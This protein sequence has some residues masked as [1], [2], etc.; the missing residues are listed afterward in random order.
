MF[1]GAHLFLRVSSQQSHRDARPTTAQTPM[2]KIHRTQL[3]VFCLLALLLGLATTPAAEIRKANNGDPMDQ[4]SS[5]IGGIAP[6]NT[7]VAV[8]DADSGSPSSPLS[9]VHWQGIRLLETLFLGALTIQGGPSSLTLGDA[10]IDM[11]AA[12]ADMD[13]NCSFVSLAADQVWNI[14]PGR[15][16]TLLPENPG[17]GALYKTGPGTLKLYYS[18]AAS[19]LSDTAA[20]GLAGGTVQL[21]GLAYAEFVGSAQ[22]YGD[23][24]RVMSSGQTLVLN[25]ITRSVGGTVDFAQAGIAS[26]STPNDA[27]EN[28][29]ILGGWATVNGQYWARAATGG[30]NQPINDYPSYYI[31]TF[32][33]TN[34][35]NLPGFTAIVTNNASLAINS[36]RFEFDTTLIVGTNGAFSLTNLTGGIL[37]GGGAIQAAIVSSSPARTLR[38]PPGG[39]LIFHVPYPFQMLS[40]QVVIADNA[41]CGLT[42]AGDGTL[43]L[44]Q[45]ANNS[46]NGLT[47][48][49][50]G[51]LQTGNVLNRRYVSSSMLINPKGTYLHGS[52]DNNLTLTAI[53]NGGVLNL[54]GAGDSCPALLLVNNGLITGYNPAKTF[55]VGNA[56][57]PL[58][59]RWGQIDVQLNVP[60]GIVKTTDRKLVFSRSNTL[61]GD[62]RVENGALQ[63][64]GDATVTAGNLILGTSTNHAKLVLGGTNGV[65]ADS[66]GSISVTNLAIEDTNL[67]GPV[68]NPIVGGSSLAGDNKLILNFG[69]DTNFNLAL[70]GGP[71]PYENNVSLTKTGAGILTLTNVGSFLGGLRNEIGTTKLTSAA[72]LQNQPVEVT[73]GLLDVNGFSPTITFLSGGGNVSSSAGGAVT[74]TLGG[75]FDGVISDGNGVV[76]VAI[77]SGYGLQL[78]GLNTY[79]GST[80][81][82]NSSL[83]LDADATIGS[84]P[85]NLASGGL[86]FTASRTGPLANP[87]KLT[88]DTTIYASGGGGPG[89]VV[90][91]FSSSD[92]TASAGTLA[93]VNGTCCSITNLFEVRFSG[94]F[95]FNRPIG[96]TNNYYQP[97]FYTGKTRLTSFNTNGTTQTYTNVISGDGSFRRSASAGTGGTTVLNANNTYSGT[98]LVDNGT[99]IVNG[100][101]GTNTVTV[102]NLGTLGGNGTIRG[103]VLVQNGGTL[104]PGTSIG[105]LTISNSLTFASGSTALMELNK[106]A[107]TNDFVTGLTSVT[108]GGTLN[109]T[110]LSGTLTNGDSF[111]LF[112]ATNYSGAFTNITP[113]TPRAG[114]VWNTSSLLT[115]GTIR[116][117]SAP[118]FDSTV[119]SGTNLVI[120]GSSGITNGSYYVLTSTNV[121]SP[122]TNWLFLLTNTFDGN[123]NFQFTNGVSPA[124][125]QRYFLLQLP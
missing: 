58:D 5:W 73:S 35:V 108:Y 102:T 56:S 38:G 113:A 122:L 112:S 51:T 2:K 85:L 70:L 14:G 29:G 115:N 77:P 67:L 66:G 41:T 74:L 43:L 3:P 119:L 53:T 39:D 104:A 110:N 25:S 114:L 124:T 55:T 123:G 34:N 54:N 83:N 42:K 90:A 32:F 17:T 125:P 7:D 48:I 109:L 61:T 15:M 91:E 65:G 45:G 92:I 37:M 63:V 18:T 16:V 23:A 57:T 36:L 69:F 22:V 44:N 71:G 94:G 11:S 117:A 28:G 118:Q 13:F 82:S 59:A 27:S 78:N 116:V 80:T 93:F 76:S 107:G 81:I 52:S 84:G 24:T 20:L 49:S 111:K 101:L 121:T 6:T 120:S 87:I 105:R 64:T 88:A 9:D 46:Y 40:N 89:D 30:G 1:S 8:W 97:A 26:T 33:E 68:F 10:G 99:L 96:V 50:G 47:T 60:G 75:S 62:T 12:T 103:P 86:V 95:T 21:E 72:N 100:G 106:A 79:S 4:G 98:T 19:H 31:T